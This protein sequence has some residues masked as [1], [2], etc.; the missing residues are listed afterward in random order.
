MK[1]AGGAAQALG[2]LVRELPFAY[3]RLRAA[4]D[5]LA[6][7]A[8][9]T[10]GKWGLMRSLAEDGPRTVAQLAR[11]RPVARQWVQRLANELAADGLIEFAENPNHRRSKLMVL[12]RKGERVLGRMEASLAQWTAE[13]SRGVDVRSMRAAVSALRRFREQLAARQTR[14]VRQA[15]S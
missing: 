1:K 7:R 9:Q 11:S 2:E 5:E 3:F 6:A 12:T 14:R 10:T 4:G 15:A 13:V 8:G